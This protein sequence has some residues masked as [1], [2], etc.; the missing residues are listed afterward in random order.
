MGA[1]EWEDITEN[2]L[3]K[4]FT[5]QSFG[6]ISLHDDVVFPY[7]SFNILEDWK[8]NRSWL[9]TIASGTRSRDLFG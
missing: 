1:V 4:Y 9:Y 3:N 5:A 2:S 7:S 6:F 8:T